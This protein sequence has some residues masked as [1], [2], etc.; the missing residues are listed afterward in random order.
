VEAVHSETLRIKKSGA[1]PLVL[2][3][4]QLIHARIS[5]QGTRAVQKAKLEK[6]TQTARKSLVRKRGTLPPVLPTG[7][8]YEHHQ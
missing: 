1:E 4:T 6:Y 2:T 7:A 3:E 8:F 5:K